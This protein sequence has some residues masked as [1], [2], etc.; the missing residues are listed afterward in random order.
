VANITDQL[1]QELEQ[2][3]PILSAISG[4]DD[5]LI[6][7]ELVDSADKVK[8]WAALQAPIQ[9]ANVVGSFSHWSR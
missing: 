1:E 2:T 8:D 9:P 4:D 7:Q 5:T 3:Y 6:E